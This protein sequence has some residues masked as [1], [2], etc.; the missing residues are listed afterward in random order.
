MSDNSYRQA[1][2][3][4]DSIAARVAALECEWERLEELREERDSWNEDARPEP[5]STTH[6]EEAEELE[7]LEAQAGG[8]ESRDEVEEAVQN[9]PLEVTVRSGWYS[10]GDSPAP[11]E[12]SILLCTG[13]PAVRIRGELGRHNEP[14]RAWIEHQ[15]WFE[16]WQE[17]HGD[18]VD[19]EALLTYCQQFY[20]GD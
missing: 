4:M 5:W 18:N 15:D 9:D 19:Q 20:F 12:F 2:A 1:A 3:Q 16:P 6:L 7:E 8:W 17:Y 13:G 11:E 14:E 10:P